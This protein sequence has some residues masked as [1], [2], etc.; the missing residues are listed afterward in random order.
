MSGFILSQLGNSSLQLHTAS[1]TMDTR[2]RVAPY[3]MDPMQRHSQK[4]RIRKDSHRTVFNASTELL[5]EILG[6]Y[7][8]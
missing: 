5:R 2:R 1:H 6:M 8:A 4:I 3:Y 7:E